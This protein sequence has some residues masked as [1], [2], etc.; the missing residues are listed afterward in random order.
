MNC[1]SSST[2]LVVTHGIIAT[3]NPVPTAKEMCGEIV[4][5]TISMVEQT[6]ACVLYVTNC[7]ALEQYHS[8]NF[9][10]AEVENLPSVVGTIPPTM[11]YV[12]S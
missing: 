9:L 7:T 11:L 10:W 1:V 8:G 5:P 4:R 2:V 12:T 3:S 6:T